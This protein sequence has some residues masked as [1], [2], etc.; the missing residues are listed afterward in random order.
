MAAS[1]FGEATTPL[2]AR[3]PTRTNNGSQRLPFFIR[4]T[5]PTPAFLRAP[6]NVRLSLPL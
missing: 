1:S 6:L 2:S 3:L 4:Q 5:L